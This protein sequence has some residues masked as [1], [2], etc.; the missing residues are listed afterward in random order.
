MKQLLKF[1]TI[2]TALIL[3]ITLFRVNTVNAATYNSTNYSVNEV[4]FGIG[5]GT[6][7]TSPNYSAQVSV[8]ETGVGAETGTN[9]SSQAGFNTTI[10]PYI[11]FIVNGGTIDI[12]T[13]STASATTTTATFSVKTYLANGYVVQTFAP[14]PSD[15]SHTFPYTSCSPN[16]SCGFSS[17]PGTEQFGINLETN[18]SPSIAGSGGPVQVPSSAFSDGQVASGY[19]TANQFRYV[20]GDTIAYSNNSTGETDYTISFLYNISPYTP[21][22]AYTYNAVLVATST[23]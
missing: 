15:G 4:F 5:G 23:Y 17:T 12:G 11:A 13:L 22:G 2:L 3:V 1:R 10:Q 14:P 9:Y 20:N 7:Y 8:G 6:G 16:P 18:S 21:D 19:N